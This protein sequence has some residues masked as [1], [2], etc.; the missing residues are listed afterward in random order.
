METNIILQGRSIRPTE[1]QQVHPLQADQPPSSR[2]RL[3]RQ[4]CELWNWRSPTGRFKDMAARSWL[5]K[6]DQ[7]G[8]ISLPPHRRFALRRARPLPGLE[9]GRQPRCLGAGLQQ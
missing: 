7:R 3:S 8:L 4:L 1:L 6:L 5:L 2:H 9:L